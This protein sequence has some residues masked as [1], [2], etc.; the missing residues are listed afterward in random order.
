[1]STQLKSRVPTD[2]LEQELELVKK[3][4]IVQLNLRE[5]ELKEYNELQKRYELLE[6]RYSALAQSFLGKLTLKYWQVRR[7]IFK[8]KASK[9]NQG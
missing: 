4:L 5:R 6:K 7:R 2:V 1:M 3:E 9:G 8:Q